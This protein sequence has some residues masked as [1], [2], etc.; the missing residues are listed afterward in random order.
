[1]KS[2]IEKIEIRLK[3]LNEAKQNLI[4]NE[5]FNIDK[6]IEIIIVNRCITE[7]NKLLDENN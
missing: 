4:K 6:D 5:F 7:L 3:E 2:I 1:M